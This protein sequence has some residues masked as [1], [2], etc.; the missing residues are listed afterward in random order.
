[1]ALLLGASSCASPV[2]PE[3]EGSSDAS[4]SSA[5]RSPSPSY[6]A[7]S[8]PWAPPTY[9]E[10]D[11]A[12]MPVT[13]PDGTTAELVYEAELKLEELSVIRTPSPRAD[14]RRVARRCMPPAT[15]RTVG[16]AEATPLSPSMS[17]RRIGRRP[18]GRD[19]FQ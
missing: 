3:A 5:S 2:E 7:E 14:P 10:G 18:V 8:E 6:L 1:M 12:V 13:F 16:G 9:R 4:E 11:H 19:P 15:T 17:P